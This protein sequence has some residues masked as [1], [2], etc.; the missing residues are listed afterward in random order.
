MAAASTA[1]NFLTAHWS[2]FRVGSERD[3]IIACQHALLLSEQFT[4]VSDSNIFCLISCAVQD[5][6]EAGVLPAGWNSS[7]E[8]YTMNYRRDGRKYVVKGL[9]MDDQ[10]LV[11]V[12][13]RLAMSY[14]VLL[15]SLFLVK[16]GQ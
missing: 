9:A 6:Q 1:E 7:Q 14:V 2:E 13:V 5:G 11:N 15:Q 12:L 4:L 16:C 8:L 10:L 3:A